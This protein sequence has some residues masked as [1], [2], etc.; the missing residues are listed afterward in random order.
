MKFDFPNEDIMFIPDCNIPSPDGGPRPGS[1][2]TLIFDGASNAKGHRI[3]AIITSPNCFHIL[4]TAILCFDST[5]N[6]VE[7][8]AC[9][10]GIE[11]SI[12]LRTNILEVYGECALVISQV[13]GDWETQDKTLIPYREHMVKLI[14]YFDEITFNY[15]PREDNQLSDAL[16]TLASMFKIKWKNEAHAIRIDHLDELAHCLEME[17]KSDDKPWFYDVK[18]YLEK[19]EYTEKA[20]ITNKKVLRRFSTK[21]FLNGDVLYKRNYDFVLLRCVDRHE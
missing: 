9:I 3:R 1:Q 8:E 4:F 2:W 14:P 19:Q 15:I 12:D 6:M 10:Y 5:N 7:Y 21:F 16:A 20:S 11:A 18:R 17:A 13:R